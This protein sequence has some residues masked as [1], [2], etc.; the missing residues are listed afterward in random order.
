MKSMNNYLKVRDVDHLKELCKHRE[1]SF[2]IEDTHNSLLI[3]YSNN[4]FKI[5]QGK[6]TTPIRVD[7][8]GLI[9]QTNIGKA[10][11]SGNLYMY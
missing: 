2:F 8:K 5:L 3:K 11:E 6:L 4:L 1:V 7:E 9:K 10:I